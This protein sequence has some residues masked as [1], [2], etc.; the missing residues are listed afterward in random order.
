MTRPT[1]TLAYDTSNSLLVLKI[2]YSLH[3]VMFPIFLPDGF[4]NHGI[5]TVVSCIN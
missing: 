5:Q 1:L 3:V 4:T 2:V